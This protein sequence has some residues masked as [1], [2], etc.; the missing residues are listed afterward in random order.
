MYKFSV[1]I[2]RDRELHHKLYRLSYSTTISWPRRCKF[3]RFRDSKPSKQ[4]GHLNLDLQHFSCCFMEPPTKLPHIVHVF[5]SLL[6]DQDCRVHQ[7]QMEG[8][9]CLIIFMWTWASSFSTPCGGRGHHTCPLEP[10]KGKEHRSESSP[11]D[12]G[13]GSL[14][15]GGQGWW[16]K[17]ASNTHGISLS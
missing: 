17:P 1:N 6:K 2:Y 5:T 13:G 16:R 11:Q 8:W 7:P 12:Q 15:H 10:N 14:W 9:D 3:L 4:M